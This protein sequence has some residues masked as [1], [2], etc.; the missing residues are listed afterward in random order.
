MYNLYNKADND[1]FIE[2]INKIT[3]DSK[4]QWGKMNAAEMLYHLR[5]PILVG[6]G[7][8]KLKRTFMGFLFG[9]IAKKQML[10][11]K[12]TKKNL[13]TDPKFRPAGKH[14]VEEEK[15]ELIKTVQRIASLGAAGITGDPHPFFG[16]LT[17][18]EWNQLTWKHLDHHL[19]QFGV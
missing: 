13:P 1:K 16:K 4:P 9:G 10:S 3:P 6:F 2:R 14:E 8:V 7:E 5:Q 18:D 11:D 12:P 19:S 17:P 15:R